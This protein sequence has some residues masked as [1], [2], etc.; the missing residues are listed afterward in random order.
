[1]NPVGRT[2]F[3][4]RASPSAAIRR[5][6]R[7]YNHYPAALDGFWGSRGAWRSNP[8]MELTRPASR[9]KAETRWSA[10][11]RTPLGAIE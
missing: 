6:R 1:M 7:Y 5:V 4:E 9:V 8:P 10:P 2:G 3:A 11:R